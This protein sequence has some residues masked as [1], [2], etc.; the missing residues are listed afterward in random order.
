MIL[1][2]KAH[3]LILDSHSEI[4]EWFKEKS[5]DSVSPFYS[6]F[7]IRDSSYK[8]APVDA[9]V[10][11]AG[12]N[13]ICDEDQDHST[14]L[15]KNFLN[16]H[17]P[18]VKKILLLCEEHTHNLHYWDNIYRI[19]ILIEDAGFKVIVCVPGKKMSTQSK[20]QSASGYVFPIHILNKE[21]GDLIISNND[22][23]SDYDLDIHIPTTPPLKMGWHIRR[24]HNFFNYYN[25]IAKEFADIIKLDPWHFSI[26]TRLFAPFDVTSEENRKELKEQVKIFLDDLTKQQLKSIQS[27]PYLFLKNNSGTYGLGVVSLNDHEEV[28]HWNYK[29]KKT[30]KASKGGRGVKELIFQEGISTSLLDKDFVAEPALYMIGSQLSGGFLRSHKSKGAKENL[31]SPGAVFKKTLRKGLRGGD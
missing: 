4:S 17:Y 5:K 2:K 28:D 1:S 18:N 26:E 12:F 22:F 13:L 3:K 8:I 25:K 14:K 10:F 21:T 23:S 30:L 27:K 11:P 20:W 9:N 16:R 24:K 29:V 31:N 7:D 6:S 19:K 15:I